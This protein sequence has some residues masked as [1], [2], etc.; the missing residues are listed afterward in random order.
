[1]ASALSLIAFRH[2]LERRARLQFDALHG[3]D[4]DVGAS[5]YAETA[6]GSLVLLAALPV[7]GLGES[8]KSLSALELAVRLQAAR[9]VKG[10]WLMP[11]LTP[12]GEY[13][14]I[15]VA[16][17]IGGWPLPTALLSG[18]VSSSEHLRP[19]FESAGG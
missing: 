11:G 3:P 10:G 12:C 18:A 7:A 14:G 4:D 5:L 1:M 8:G 15:L 2:D 9:A 17:E 6:P 13:L 19:L 16:A